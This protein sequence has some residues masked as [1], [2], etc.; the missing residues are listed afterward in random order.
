[1]PEPITFFC[2]TCDTPYKVMRVEAPTGK[3]ER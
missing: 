3:D 1:M 2:P